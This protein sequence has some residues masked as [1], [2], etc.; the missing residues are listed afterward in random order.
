MKRILVSEFVRER[1]NGREAVAAVWFRP[2]AT[3]A[4]CF[5]LSARRL[6]SGPDCKSPA[7]HIEHLKAA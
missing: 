6:H 7:S 4:S 2:K 5:R 1:F 3:V